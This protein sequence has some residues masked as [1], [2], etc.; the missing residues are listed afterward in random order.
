MINLCS[1]LIEHAKNNYYVEIG[2][3]LSSPTTV[4]NSYWFLVYEAKI[5]L[6]R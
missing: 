1:K 3:K 2:E 6:N 5:P 4:I